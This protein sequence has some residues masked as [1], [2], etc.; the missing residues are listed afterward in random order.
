MVRR[1]EVGFPRRPLQALCNPKFSVP[2]YISFVKILLFNLTRL[3]Y[4]DTRTLIYVSVLIEPPG[5]GSVGN[6]FPPTNSPVDGFISGLGS[7]S[8]S[9]GPYLPVIRF[10]ASLLHGD[11]GV[12]STSLAKLLTMY[13]TV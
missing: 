11:G 7:R 10:I 12:G 9:S 13:L 4:R 1:Q 2:W 3:S 8:L 6:G 5:G